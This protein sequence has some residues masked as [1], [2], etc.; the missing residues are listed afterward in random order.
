[1]K[2]SI[3]LINRFARKSVLVTAGSLLSMASFA[4][5]AV[6]IEDILAAADDNTVKSCDVDDVPACAEAGTSVTFT[7]TITEPGNTPIG[8][9]LIKSGSTRLG[10]TNSDGTVTVS[11]S[12]GGA[13]TRVSVNFFRPGERQSCAT[14]TINCYKKDKSG[15]FI[16]DVANL[17]QSLVTKGAVNKITMDNVLD[18]EFELSWLEEQFIGP[19]PSSMTINTTTVALAEEGVYRVNIDGYHAMYK[20]FSSRLTDFTM[21]DVHLKGD[22]N[23]LII[24]IKDNSVHGF[25]Q[26]TVIN[27]LVGADQERHMEFSGSYD[28]ALLTLDVSGFLVTPGDADV[29][30]VPADPVELSNT[31]LL[32]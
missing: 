2:N 25:M 29:E 17:S 11:A 8:G 1:M 12:C 27:N 10:S 26:T 16:I 6:D 22:D 21:T 3:Q 7:P 5:N 13:G 30:P 15:K 23:Y 31:D 24:D 18:Y 20:P 14:R 4:S 32:K 9:V 19:T 28:G